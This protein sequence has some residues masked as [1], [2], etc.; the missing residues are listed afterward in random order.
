MKTQHNRNSNHSIQVEPLANFDPAFADQVTRWFDRGQ[1]LQWIPILTSESF[2]LGSAQALEA[3]LMA[4]IGKRARPSN[5]YLL[6]R[7]PEDLLRL[8]ANVPGWLLPAHTNDTD[9]VCELREGEVYVFSVAHRLTGRKQTLRGE[10]DDS[11]A[12]S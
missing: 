4:Q 12:G 7:Q 2:V 5:F 8:P 9:V 3:R 6:I 10:V 1:L 11:Q